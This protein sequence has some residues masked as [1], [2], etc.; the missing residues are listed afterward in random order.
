MDTRVK[1]A[2]DAVPGKPKRS[3]LFF[4]LSKTLGIMLLPSNF[5]IGL[6][7]VGGVLLLT[8]F[9]RVGRKLVIACPLLLAVCGF[10]PLGNLLLYPLEA[11]FPPWDAARGAPDGIIVLGGSIDP[12]LSV[13][14][15]VA[16]FRGSVD[17]V[18]A[19]AELAHRYPQAR[20]V[21][22]G[23]SAN[24]VADNSAKEADYAASIFEGLGISRGRLI[25]ERRSRNTEENAAFSKAL[26]SPNPGERWVLVTS[27]YHVPRSVGI[28]R[29]AGFAVEPYPADWHTGGPRDLLTFSPLSVDGLARTDAAVREWMGLAAYWISGKTGALFPG[30]EQ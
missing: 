5:L 27:A 22:S 9:A 14:H 24:L 16:V 17:R 6:G 8:R 30:P 13:A 29:K 25:M 2:Y 23:G 1:P 4:A 19:A 3:C 7:L 11:R 21:F 28:F 12:E 18:I 10:S 20:I 26:V 15:G